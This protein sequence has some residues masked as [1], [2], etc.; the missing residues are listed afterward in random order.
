MSAKLIFLQRCFYD[1]DEGKIHFS[2]NGE[3]F[4]V[5]FSV[6]NSPPLFPAI[7]LKNAEVFFVVFCFFV[8]LFF[9][10]VFLAFIL[11]F[12]N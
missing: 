11:F 7:V 1:A 8:F 3:E 4:P 2:V 5:A 6:K 12:G 9:L 10:F